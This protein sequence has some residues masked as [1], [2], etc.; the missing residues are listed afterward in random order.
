MQSGKLYSNGKACI[1]S[2]DRTSVVNGAY[3]ASR[4]YI[5]VGTIYIQWGSFSI[6]GNSSGSQN[7]MTSFNG[8]PYSAICT[9]DYNYTGGQENYGITGLSS[10]SITIVNGEGSTRTFRWIAIGPAS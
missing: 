6:A 8:S 1:T 5:N 4:G 3:K 9:W 7:F 10:T 2:D